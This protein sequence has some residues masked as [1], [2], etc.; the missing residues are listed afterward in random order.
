MNQFDFPFGFQSFHKDR[1]INFHLNRWYSLGYLPKGD[2]EKIGHGS[3]DTGDLKRVL[4]EYAEEM[5]T[6]D[7]TLESAIGYRA[8]EFFT[9]PRDKD[10][11]PLYHEFQAAFYPGIKAQEFEKLRIPYQNG[12]L[13]VLRFSPENIRGAILIH[14]GLDSFMEELFTA[15]YYLSQAGYEVILF[16]GPGQG[17][18]LRESNLYMTHRWEEPVSAVLDYLQLDEVTLIGVSLG[19][20][21]ALR[22]AA[23]EKRISRVVAFDIFVYDQHGS[24]LQGAV[25]KFFLKYPAT[26]NWVARTAMRMSPAADHLISQWMDILNSSTPAEYVAQMQYYSVSDIADQV[27]QDVLL[28]AGEED[29]MIPLGELKKHQEGLV[30]ARSITC[31]IFSADEHAENHCQVGNIKLALDVILDWISNTD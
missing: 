28:L 11:L 13:P 19:G 30:N 15:A 21:L 31:R 7:R 12:N 20:Y 17:A 2:L 29:H 9:H 24:G 5:K 1:H 23:F 22:A 25:Y 14:G 6:E 4:I 10:K 16:D 26:Y 18:A 3:P 8:A 27:T